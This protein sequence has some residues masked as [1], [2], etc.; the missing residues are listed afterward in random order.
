MRTNMSI[1]N[2]EHTFGVLAPEEEA[3]ARNFAVLLDG[4]TVKDLRQ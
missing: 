2:P 3:R 1:P 4:V